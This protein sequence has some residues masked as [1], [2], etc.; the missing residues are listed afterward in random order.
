MPFPWIVILVGILAII[1]GILA[2]FMRKKEKA[3]TDY[4]TLVVMGIIFTGA[5]IP[6]GNY[7]L[8]ALGIIFMVVG[9]KNKDKWK[10]NHR[11]LKELPK[12]KRQMIF[13]LIA[14]GLE[15]FVGL[16]SYINVVR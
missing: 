13:L 12:G 14:M 10:K 7:A 6:L 5:G 11:P 3:Q 1:T 9:L 15:V 16:V 2:L 4:Y 8:S